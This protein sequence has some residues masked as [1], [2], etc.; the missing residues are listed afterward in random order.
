LRRKAPDAALRFVLAAWIAV[1]AL[2]A[3]GWAP[4]MALFAFVPLLRQAMV[5]LY[6]MPSWSMATAVL[7][8]FTVRDWQ[9]GQRPAWILPAIILG[10]LAGVGLLWSAGS[11]EAAPRFLA[12]S[13]ILV[14]VAVVT[15]TFW[16]LRRPATQGCRRALVA[17][18]GGYATALFMLPLFAGTHGRRLDVPA[19]QFL[20]S[21]ASDGRVVSFGPLVP[22]YGAM[23]G[24]AEI[25][26]NYLPV[27]RVW[28]WTLRARLQPDSDGV[29]FY[30]GDLPSPSMLHKI[31][32]G[33]RDMGAAYVV[34]W[35]WETLPA[36]PGG[37]VLTYHDAIMNIFALPDPMPYLD[38]P[39]CLLTG[40]HAKVQADCP[41][42]AH[43]VRRELFWPG[44]RATLN[45][46]AAPLEPNGIFQSV[47]LPPGRSEV[48]FRYAPPG[49]FWAF[50]MCALG[51]VALLAASLGPGLLQR[52]S[53][54][55]Q[56]RLLVPPARE[57][58]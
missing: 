15:A 54:W 38:A 17:L 1:T 7:A 8:S 33:Y 24:I 57:T 10:P 51:A 43:L 30:D 56:T 22:N 36:E 29:N 12:A 21:H 16:I 13:S 3:A 49:I 31:L 20:Q 28:V 18:V 40:T 2:R 34:T 58:I 19:I 27:P 45:G 26:H 52:R 47:T 32:P 53:G 42:P 23:F 55:L 11:L 46:V 9:A 5:H 25:N 41:L 50:A 37:A 44:W 14:P 4:V 35:P 48:V 6:M 39:G